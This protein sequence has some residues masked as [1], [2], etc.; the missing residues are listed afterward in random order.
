MI[1]EKAADFIREDRAA[2][3]AV[4]LEDDHASSTRHHPA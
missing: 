1:G 4:S 2:R 3:A